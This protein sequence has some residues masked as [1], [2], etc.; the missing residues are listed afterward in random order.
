M[1]LLGAVLGRRVFAV[2]GGL[3]I[4]GYL[5][6]LS[7]RVFKDSLVFPFALSLIGLAIIW[8][9]VIWQRN[10]AQWSVKL[11]AS[12]PKELRELLEARGS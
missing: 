11:R 1:V 10:E 12:L 5:G 3:G 6:H 4:A 2:F 9:G 8:L 7:Y